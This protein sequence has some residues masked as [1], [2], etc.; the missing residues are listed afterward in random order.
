MTQL[1]MAKEKDGFPVT[2][3]RELTTLLNLRHENIVQ[4][5]EVVVGS[6]LDKI[7]MVMEYMEHD[8]KALMDAMKTPFA[9]SEVKCLL[10]QLLK[11]VDYMHDHY[12]LHRC[13]L[14]CIFLKKK[15]IPKLVDF[16][17]WLIALCHPMHSFDY[18]VTL[19]RVSMSVTET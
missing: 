18:F 1:K 5:K 16:F 8:L 19:P 17:R 4:V 10:L 3:L 14:C 6:S 11:A 15:V 12:I 9:Q 2:A 7:Y 13:D